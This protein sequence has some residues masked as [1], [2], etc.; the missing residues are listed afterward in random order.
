MLNDNA[1]DLSIMENGKAMINCDERSI[2]I[3]STSYPPPQGRRKNNYFCNISR[4]EGREIRR[5]FNA[6]SLAPCG[7]GKNFKTRNEF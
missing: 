4:E 5:N 6:L 7:R 3:P 1:S 2:L